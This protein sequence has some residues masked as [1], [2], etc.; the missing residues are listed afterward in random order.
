V[1]EGATG[2]SAEG[3]RQRNAALATRSTSGR[4]SVSMRRFAVMPGFSSS[5]GFSTETMAV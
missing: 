3:G 4:F 5:R 2:A 1:A